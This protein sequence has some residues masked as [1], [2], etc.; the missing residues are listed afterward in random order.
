M[1]EIKVGVVDVF[2]IDPRPD[3]WKVL[4]LRRAAGTRCTG[5]WEVVHGRIEGDERPEDAAIREMREETGLAPLRL[6]NV[7]CHPFYLHR[8]GVVQVAVVFAAF[9]DSAV[10]PT[11]GAE[12]DQGEWVG[13]EEAMERLVWPRSRHSLADI[14]ALL[15]SGDAGPVEDVLRVL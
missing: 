3:G 10:A 1:A 2:V 11:L 9:A 15:R 12:H 4:V 13:V 5:A 6:Y 8:F 7:T 14:R